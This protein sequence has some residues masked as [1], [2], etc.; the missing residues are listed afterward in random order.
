MDG[1]E[2]PM[3]DVVIDQRSRDLGGFSVGRVLPYSHRRMVGPFIFFDHFGPVRFEPG[4]PRSV[5]VRPH[6]HIGLS[7]VTYLFQ[8]EIIHRDSLGFE[9]AIRPAE[10][11]WMTAGRGITHSER[12]EKARA[13]G[14]TMHGLQAWVAL[15]REHEETDPSFV[16]YAGDDMPTYESGGLWAR[17]V[18]GEAFGARS[19]VSTLSPMFYVHWRLQRG[20]KA[21]LADEYP[22]RAAFVA[23]GA[24]E[25]DGRR[26]E[27]GQM[28]VFSA[29]GVVDFT[30]TTDATVMLLGGEPVG[31]RFLEWNFVS[32]SSDRIEQAKADWRAGR[33]KLPDLDNQEFIPLP[34]GP[35]P[36]AT[37]MS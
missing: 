20:A 23:A 15:P 7:T 10:L 28:I 31:E 18:V 30:A 24:V 36:P 13:E 19:T 8:G 3:I 2:L 22:E 17:L 21:Q 25:V 32:S 11:N 35:P 5:D 37:P 9:Q 12:F 4:I 34:G 29:G 27:T 1:K 33:M 6:P 16:H 26:F 14:D